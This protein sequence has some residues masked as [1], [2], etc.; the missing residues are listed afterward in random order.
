MWNF[1]PKNESEK[2]RVKSKS[3]SEECAPEDESRGTTNNTNEVPGQSLTSITIGISVAGTLFFVAFVILVIWI[4]FK[5]PKN[6]KEIKEDLN[7]VTKEDLNVHYDTA[8]VDYEYLIVGN[9]YSTWR[10]EVVME[11]VDRNSLYGKTGEG[12]EDAI[13][14]DNSSNFENWHFFSTPNIFLNNHQLEGEN[15]RFISL[16]AQILS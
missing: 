14:L 12:W 16:A 5:I 13:T 3:N 1:Y 15:C 6:K 8:G 7:D 4:P 2:N 9:T 11:V 10:R